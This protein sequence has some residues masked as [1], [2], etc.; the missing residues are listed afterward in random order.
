MA[1]EGHWTHVIAAWAKSI[2][3]RKQEDFD[4]ALWADMQNVLQEFV[5]H[6]ED[7]EQ[8]IDAYAISCGD[9]GW[10]RR[11][12]AH[13]GTLY[14][15]HTVAAQ[16][17]CRLMVGAL[18]F[19]TGWSNH[20]THDKDESEN[21]TAL[22]AMMRCIVA[23]VFAYILAEIKCKY[24]WPA[25]DQAWYIMRGMGQP[26]GV[27]TSIS[28]GTCTLDAYKN[29]NIGTGNLQEAVKQWLKKSKKISASI[30]EIED[31]PNC[32]IEWKMYKN[33]M[34]QSGKG[35]DLSSIFQEHHMQGLVKQQVTKMFKKITNTVS[36]KVE[37]ARKKETGSMGS[38]H[39]DLDSSDEDEEEDDEEQQNAQEDMKD[40][41]GKNTTPKTTNTNSTAATD[42]PADAC[43]HH[44]NNAHGKPSAGSGVTGSGGGKSLQPSQA[45][46]PASPVLPARPPQ[47]EATPGA[48]AAGPVPQPPPAAPPPASSSSGSGAGTGTPSTDTEK[49]GKCSKPPLSATVQ[50]AGKGLAG[51]KSITTITFGTSSGTE[52][53]CGNKPK[54][55]R[56]GKETPDAA[57]TQTGPD[58]KSPAVAGPSAEAPADSTGHTRSTWSRKRLTSGTMIEHCELERRLKENELYVDDLLEKL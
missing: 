40:R 58:H 47:P 11:G 45:Q 5:D 26:G 28:A 12:A 21:D 17:K 41:T 30:K 53:A 18:Y 13:H 57:P 8:H 14:T 23:H 36:K 3:L 55:S 10:P 52:D 49:P 19:V 56:E 29:T 46:A 27:E 51:A 2:V 16:M 31:N 22:K 38:E 4:S 42:K 6:M 54:D 44:N 50:N 48:G 7:T 37:Q 25:I 20:M 15:G 24:E 43:R 39:S 32:N 35:A 33:S 34:E 1:N 9:A